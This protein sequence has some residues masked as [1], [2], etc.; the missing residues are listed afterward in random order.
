[1]KLISALAITISCL[2]F[3]SCNEPDEPSDEFRY[4]VDNDHVDVYRFEPSLVVHADSGTVVQEIL[5]F[6]DSSNRV[7]ITSEYY[8]N[9]STNSVSKTASIK[10]FSDDWRT[11]LQY[12]EVDDTTFS[13]IETLPD[14]SCVET[15]YQ[16]KNDYSC[17]GNVTVDY[18]S[19]GR[20]LRP[21]EHGSGATGTVNLTTAKFTLSSMYS[22]YSQSNCLIHHLQLNKSINNKGPVYVPLLRPGFFSDQFG[23]ILLEV[24]D[25][26]RIIVYE[27][28]WEI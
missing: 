20:I 28:G 25:Y 11:T 5:F 6:G 8:E 27:Y 1:M 13:C 23:W 18:I 7:E 15:R 12:R 10:P 9:S 24:Q 21:V 26:N 22:G 3:I 4:G 17:S 14:N 16:S 19:T 2:L